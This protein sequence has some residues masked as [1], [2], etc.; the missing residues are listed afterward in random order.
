[1]WPRTS[2]SHFDLHQHV[3]IANSNGDN[4]IPF[5]KVVFGTGNQTT[6]TWFPMH[7]MGEISS[8]AL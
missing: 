7:L 3:H 8:R 5:D 1:M 6:P 4:I 2:T